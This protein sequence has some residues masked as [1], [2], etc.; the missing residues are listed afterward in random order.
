MASP[1]GVNRLDW[2]TS[3]QKAGAWLND[4]FEVNRINIKQILT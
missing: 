1:F 4:V 3:A 2:L